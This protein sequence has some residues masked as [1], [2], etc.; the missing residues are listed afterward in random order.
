MAVDKKDKNCSL[1]CRQLPLNQQFQL[2]ASLQIA[3]RFSLLNVVSGHA[4]S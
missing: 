2:P 4:P 1:A 3:T